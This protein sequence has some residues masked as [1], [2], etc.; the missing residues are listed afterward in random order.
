MKHPRRNIALLMLSLLLAAFVAGC[1]DRGVHMPK[2]R[3]RTHC[4]CPTFS[5]HIVPQSEWTSRP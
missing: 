3:K 5:E 4:D 1:S 2:H